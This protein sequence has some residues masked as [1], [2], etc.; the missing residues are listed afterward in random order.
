[1][2]GLSGTN[3]NKTNNKKKTSPKSKHLSQKNT[4]EHLDEERGGIHYR[5]RK[6]LQQTFFEEG[7]TWPAW[8]RRKTRSR[9]IV[10]GMTRFRKASWVI[11]DSL[12]TWTQNVSLLLYVANCPLYT[13][14]QYFVSALYLFPHFLNK[15][16]KWDWLFY[17]QPSLI[18]AG[19]DLTDTINPLFAA[20]LISPFSELLEHGDRMEKT[21]I[22]RKKL[23]GC[24]LD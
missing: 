12:T 19:A 24:Y 7:I 11:Q 1:M 21:S 8:S 5:H 16:R 18:P 6:R 10:S 13:T 20:S 4:S 22:W 14:N 3:Q 9:H 23:K 15:V 2:P 17:F